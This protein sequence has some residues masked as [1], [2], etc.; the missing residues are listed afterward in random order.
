MLPALALLPLPGSRATPVSPCESVAVL[1]RNTLV[2]TASAAYGPHGRCDMRIRDGAG[3]RTVRIPRR[4]DE[5]YETDSPKLRPVLTVARNVRGW[6][7]LCVTVPIESGVYGYR[8]L[9]VYGPFAAG[10]GAEVR[11]IGTVEFSDFG[12]W[13]ATPRGTLVTW[14]ADRTL[15]AHYAPHPFVVQRFVLGERMRKLSPVSTRRSYEPNEDDR[16]PQAKD[17]L[18]ELGL[19]WKWWGVRSG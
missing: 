1:R 19:V 9:T 15:G 7:Y 6:R 3:S 4:Q 8:R 10:R 5:S 14:D 12:S 11:A 2:V 17:P 18:R 13:Y 16:V